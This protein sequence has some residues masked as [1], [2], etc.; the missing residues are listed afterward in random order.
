VFLVHRLVRRRTAV[1]LLLVA[2]IVVPVAAFK[3]A[4]ARAKLVGGYVA[5]RDVPVLAG[6]RV[7]PDDA[8]EYERLQRALTEYAARRPGRPI[9]VLGSNAL[10]A[11]FAS[12][13]RNPQPYFVQL[14]DAPAMRMRDDALRRFVER[15]RAIVLVEPL[16][17]ATIRRV[18]GDFGYVELARERDRVLLA[19]S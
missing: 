14:A 8:A 16:R 19:P 1:A 4:A 10:V 7:S 5:V 6:M 17:P 13:L 3:A 9:V 2:T 15:E 12:D 11:T 18:I